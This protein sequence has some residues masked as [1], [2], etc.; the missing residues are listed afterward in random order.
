MFSGEK[1]TT[2]ESIDREYRR[3]AGDPLSLPGPALSY[4]AKG[5]GPVSGGRGLVACAC[6]AI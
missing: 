4:S 5:A 3:F 2:Q 1:K 6:V